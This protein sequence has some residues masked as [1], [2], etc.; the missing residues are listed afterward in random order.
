MKRRGFLGFLGGAVAAGPAMAKQAATVGMEAMSLAGVNAAAAGSE[1]EASFAWATAPGNPIAPI[2]P[3]DPKH[4]IQQE[5]RELVGMTAEERE[6]RRRCT[7]VH[8]LDPDLAANRSFSLA[9]KVR[10]QRDRNFEREMTGQK[11]EMTRRLAQA[12]RDWN[13]RQLS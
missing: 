8:G 10:L 4:W 12:I 7:R 1:I 13:E 3:L 5:L 6:R 2:S 11:E 9:A